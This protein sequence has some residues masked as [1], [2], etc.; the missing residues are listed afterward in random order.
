MWYEIVQRL[1]FFALLHQLDEELS[2]KSRQSR[3]PY[4][5]GPLHQSNY[6]RK[7]RGV[8]ETVPEE[9]LLRFS[10]CCGRPECRCRVL[11]PSVKFL[12]RRIYWGGIILVAMALR[13]RRPNGWTARK[14][15]LAL[16]IP[17]KTLSRWAQ[18]WREIFP[19][20]PR[21]KELRGKVIAVVQDTEL[22]GA[23]LDYFLQDNAPEEEALV[24]CLRFLAT[25]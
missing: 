25:G 1:R 12:G 5:G 15:M 2:Q 13:Q 23:L 6:Q 22:P 9:Y 10:N 17:E 18:Y 14:V 7:P 24:G 21:W 11:P 20:S 4:C 3:C 19:E 16:E 8:S